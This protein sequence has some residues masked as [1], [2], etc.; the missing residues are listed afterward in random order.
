MKIDGG[1]LKP[2]LPSSSGISKEWID[3]DDHRKQVLQEEME[4]EHGHIINESDEPD[5]LIYESNR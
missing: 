5:L 4:N 3:I 1:R 2:Q